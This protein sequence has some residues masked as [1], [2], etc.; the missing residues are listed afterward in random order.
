MHIPGAFLLSAA[1]LAGLLLNRVHAQDMVDLELILAVD[2]SM[3]MGENERVIQRDGYA[4]AFREPIIID[5]ITG[6]H[7]GAIA[8]AYLEWAGS[9]HAELRIPWTHIDSR[10][11]ALGFADIIA[12]LPLL[13]VDRTSI[14][15][16]LSHAGRAI[17]G[18]RWEGARRVID[19][20]G[21]GPNNQGEPVVPVR[22]KLVDSGIVINGLPL[23]VE[24][25]F[26]GFNIDNLDRYYEECVT[27]GPGSFVIPVYE[28]QH[29]ADAV[30][31]KLYLE[32]AGLSPAH[33]PEKSIQ[34]VSAEADNTHSQ[35][36]C[37]I[38]ERKW[39]E[40]RERFNFPSE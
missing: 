5:A 26:I 22:D 28:W 12:N 17:I 27:G 39:R 9:R 21:D 36:D 1:L 32:I 30:K 10:D 31:R 18:N 11:G 20:S 3:S 8:V 15:N 16:A 37:Q 33:L 24:S 23:M 7:Y 6:G 40:F 4:Q 13:R 35:V 19:I 25:N 38:G 2:V 34:P 29:F 14:S